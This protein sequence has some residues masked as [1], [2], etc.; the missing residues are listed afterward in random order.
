MRY[1][2][3][4]IWGEKARNRAGSGTT[5]DYCGPDGRHFPVYSAGLTKQRLLMS[6]KEELDTDTQ[7]KPFII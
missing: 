3:D 5:R 4:E 2:G 6:E 7:R 1:R